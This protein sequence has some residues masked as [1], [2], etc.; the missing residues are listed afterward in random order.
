[1]KKILLGLL[2]GA[3]LFAKETIYICDDGAEWPPFVFYK[4]VDGK[5]D[6]SKVE[7]ALVDMYNVI[8]KDLNMSYKLDLIPWKRCTYLVEHY[9][10]AK[11]YVIF[12][13][14]YNER[15]AK[16]LNYTK[17]PIYTTHQVIWYSKNRF[18]EEEIKNKVKNDINS[19]KVCDVNG[20]NTEF[21]YTV[22]RLDKNKKINQ[23]ATSQCAVLKKIS[24]GRCDI[25]VGSKE[26]ILG[27]K[28][29]GKCDIPK[30][31]AYIPDERLK[32]SNFILF[33]SKKGYPQGKELTEKLDKE[34]EKLDK[35]GLKEKIM[36]KWLNSIK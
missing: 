2:I 6:K 33:I 13:G 10:K 8:F 32:K 36:Q 29:I 34:L 16:V 4:R 11:K 31:I 18:S 3:S 19:L 7:G 24:A 22:L 21:Y 26:S 5:I 25:M 17:N 30:D 14:L 12:P 23:E 27:T 9:D 35:S 20:Y 1:M 28:M 15:R